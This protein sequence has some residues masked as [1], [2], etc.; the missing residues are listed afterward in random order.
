MTN[1]S[2]FALAITGMIALFFGSVLLLGG[3]RFFLV[4]LP[5]VGF[6]FGFGVGA[7][8]IQA[9]FGDG[10]LATITGWVV[11]FGLALVFAVLSYL[12]YIAAVGMVGAAIGYG[13]AEGILQAIGLNF[14]PLVWMV[15]VVVAFLFGAAT[16][17][18][19]IQKWV[20][21][22]A[23]ALLGAGVI[24]WTF[25]YL[26]GGLP[27]AEVTASPVRSVLRQSLLWSVSY[28]VMVALGVIVQ[29]QSTRRF[30]VETYN[31]AA[32]LVGAEPQPAQ[33]EAPAI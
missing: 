16:V 12:F 23:T 1:E 8:S 31:R 7:Q 15:A 21:I 24:V 10:F 4:L 6:F 28:V 25:L 20:V 5:I 9:L 33:Q 26:F 18:L 11:G 14:G 29:Y 19:N 2:F 13:L 32:E 3:Y 30:E 22:G 27:A 17:L